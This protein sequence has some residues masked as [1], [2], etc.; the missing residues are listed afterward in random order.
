VDTVVGAGLFLG[1]AYG[2]DPAGAGFGFAFGRSERK[3]AGV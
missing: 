3:L 1:P 2:I